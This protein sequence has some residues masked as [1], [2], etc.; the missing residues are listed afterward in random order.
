MLK[1]LGLFLLGLLPLLYLPMR[2]LMHAPLNEADPSTPWR[3][4]LL[5][6]GGSFLAE[7]SEEGRHCSPSALALADPSTK[8]GLLGDQLLGQFPDPLV[9]IGILAA[10]YLFFRDR[11]A[12]ILLGMLLLGCLGQSVV[13]LQ[14]GIE[15][16]YVFLI[17]AFLAFG[18]CISA[19]PRSLVAVE[20]NLTVGSATRTTHS[21]R[22]V[23]PDAGRTALGFAR[24]YAAHDRSGDLGGRKTIEAVAGNVK[25]EPRFCITGARSG[26]WCW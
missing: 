24:V 20:E 19:G 18:L 10:V 1:G 9:L 5:V 6:T 7:S 14:L 23:L 3:F 25:Q 2:A 21:L 22:P 12:A 17:P 8:L 11:A 26:T 13:Y 15:D 4:L 16:F